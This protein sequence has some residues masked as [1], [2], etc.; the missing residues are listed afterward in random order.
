[1]VGVKRAYYLL[2]RRVLSTFFGDSP[3]AGG[4]PPMLQRGAPYAKIG[5]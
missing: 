1:M 4:A 5:G 2:T 3:G